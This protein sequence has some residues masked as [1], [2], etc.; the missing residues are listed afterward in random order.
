[1][2]ESSNLGGAEANLKQQADV[3]NK[4]VK[5]NTTPEGKLDPAMLKNPAI[6][7]ILQLVDQYN[8]AVL[9]TGTVLP[10]SKK[11]V[12]ELIGGMP[13]QI[14][15][16]DGLQPEELLQ[17]IMFANAGPDAVQTTVQHTGEASA[18][19]RSREQNATALEQ[20][21]MTTEA[22]KESARI[23]GTYT[24]SGSGPV[25]DPGLAWD[26]F[27][28]NLNTR[29]GTADADGYIDLGNID[30]YMQQVILSKFPDTDG[31]NDGYVLR[32]EGNDVALYSVDKKGNKKIVGTF[33]K[34][35]FNKSYGDYQAKINSGKENQNGLAPNNADP[36]AEYS[37]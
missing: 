16:Q 28:E 17:L 26:A 33:A 5:E 6:G 34:N 35:T 14:N 8:S 32:K 22:Q 21:R 3:F 36:F 24:G 31:V 12:A 2:L 13:E 30:A 25:S 18:N 11:T 19:R 1:L 23:R 7:S 27:M 15:V 9:K 37:F 29:Q 10:G 4:I 20:T